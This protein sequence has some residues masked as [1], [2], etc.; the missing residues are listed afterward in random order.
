MSELTFN[1]AAHEYRFGG[2]VVPSVTQILRPL[3]NFSMVPKDVLERASQFGRAVHKA[4]ELY[5]LGSLDEGALDAALVPYLAGWK[6]FSSEHAVKWTVIEQ[7]LYS[8][9]H[10]YAG[11]PDRFGTVDG[12]AAV[13]DIKSS[14]ALY[15]SVGPQLAAYKN[16]VPGS[17]PIC[18]RLGV[19]LKPDGTYEAKEYPDRDDWSLF[20]SLLTMRN[21]CGRHSI[22]PNYTE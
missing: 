14:V 6:K 17:P 7:P 1:E 18:R 22:T 10:R 21:W 20:L 4:C 9:L 12:K 8:D 15:P 5:D 3:S 13:V 2:A 16:I 11:T 19:R